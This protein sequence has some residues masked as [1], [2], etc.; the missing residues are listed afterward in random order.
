MSPRKKY[1]TEAARIAARRKSKRKSAARSPKRIKGRIWRLVIPA[2][3]GY[4]VHPVRPH[5]SLQALKLQI[6]DSLLIREKS[7]SLIRWCI[8][9]QT[10]QGS[11]L[12][13]LDIFLEYE[14][15]VLNSSKRYDYLLKHGDLTRYRTVNR[16][17]IQYGRKEDP[18][19]LSNINSSEQI[20][21]ERDTKRDLYS[22]AEKA[23]IQDPFNFKME[24]WLCD[25]DL[26]RAVSKTTYFKQKRLLLEYQQGLC[27]KRLQERPGIKLIVR[28]HI[29]D[30]LNRK[31]WTQFKSWVGYQV[32]IDHINQIVKWRCQRP[33]KTSNL[34]IVGKP[35]TGKTTLFRR[36]DELVASYPMGTHGAWFPDYCD[37]VFGFLKWEEFTLNKYPYDLLLKLLEGQAAKLPV[38]GSHAFR[39][40]N[41]LITMTSNLKL[42][43]HICN[44]FKSN[45]N[46]NHARLNLASRITEVVI[47]DGKDLFLLLKLLKK[48]R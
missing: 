6:L 22:T 3:Q 32:I 10:H 20:L 15:G 29:R 46:R 2:I 24:R 19:P 47:P 36:L 14:R 12:P 26:Y 21:L 34:L 17:I 41:Q 11:G 45:T 27:H 18:K 4:G 39:R 9:W 7:R 38:K 16:A 1:K 28:K 44:R 33:H 42:Q 35:D 40:D 37:G 30:T 13:H 23:M 8:A 43:Q 5:P 31:E 48:S 25:N